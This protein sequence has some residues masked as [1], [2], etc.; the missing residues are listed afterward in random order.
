MDVYVFV[1]ENQPLSPCEK[2]FKKKE[3]KQIVEVEKYQIV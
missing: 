2:D 1:C 3:K